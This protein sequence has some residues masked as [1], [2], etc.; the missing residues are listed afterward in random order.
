MTS[1]R[2][3]IP[4]KVLEYEL[5]LNEILREDL[6]KVLDSRDQI[7]NQIAEYLQLRT[8]IERMQESKVEKDG[9]KTKIDLGCNFYAQAIVPN[10]S[11]IFV[12]IG[13]GFFVEFTLPEAL[14]FIEK[15]VG[16]LTE[17]SEKL[18]KHSAKIKVHIKLVL[19]GLKELQNISDQ[20]EEYKTVPV[21]M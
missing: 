20:P 9:L 14:K 2:P 16:Q 11:R 5:F 13:F 6:R 21:V 7:Y 15:K 19:E 10:A 18:T 12:A 1:E 17:K 4:K 8:V 3:D